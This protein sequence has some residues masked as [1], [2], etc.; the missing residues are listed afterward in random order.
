MAKVGRP[1][2]I[3]G[4]VDEVRLKLERQLLAGVMAYPEWLDEA[5]IRCGSFQKFSDIFALGAHR[6]LLD[7]MGDIK[8]LGGQT[9]PV[10]VRDSLICSGDLARIGGVKYLGDVAAEVVVISTLRFVL[11]VLEG[12]PRAPLNN[13]VPLHD[14]PDVINNKF[15][16]SDFDGRPS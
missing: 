12:A 10:S 14:A 8:Y 2:N 15:D 1:R 9:D 16:F 11:S 4:D 7:A 5:I 3:D 13:V 6:V